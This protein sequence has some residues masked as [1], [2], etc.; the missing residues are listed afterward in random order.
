MARVFTDATKPDNPI[1]FANDS[2][3]SWT[4]Y[5]EVLGKNFNF[6]MAH[7]PDAE[8][9]TRIEAE[10]EGSS[11]RGAE[12]LYF[13]RMELTPGRLYARNSECWNV[14]SPAWEISEGDHGKRVLG[15][16]WLGN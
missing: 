8:A 9:L 15:R 6:L 1:I 3:L 13:A 7:G 2:F 12:V 5:E 16:T 10:F 4:A 14:A 11:S